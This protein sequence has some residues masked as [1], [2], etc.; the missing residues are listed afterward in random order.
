[1]SAK[2]S[3]FRILLGLLVSALMLASVHTVHA[4]ESTRM[5]DGSGLTAPFADPALTWSTFLGGSGG[6]FA[7][8]MAVDATGNV[9]VI[10]YSDSDWG[11]PIRAFDSANDAF[12]A[13]FDSS[14]NLLWNTF[15]GGGGDDVGLS[16]VTSG[17]SIFVAG[18]SN[19]T[20]DCSPVTCTVN[21]YTLG[22][23][24]FAAKLDSSGNVSWITFLG[25][26]GADF[27]R[28]IA[29]D[30]SGNIYV[31]GASDGT[32]GA[33]IQSHAGGDY[34]GFAAKLNSSGALTWNTFQGSGGHDQTWGIAVDVSG[35]A[36][37]TGYSND[38]WGSPLIAYDADYDGFAA[39]L[40]GS[41]V[42]TWNTFLGGSAEDHSSAIFLDGSGV[43]LT[44]Y[45]TDG[46]GSPV[47]AYTSGNDVFAAKLTSSGALTWN[48]FLGGTGSDAGYAI[49][50]NGSDVYV[51]GYSTDTWGSPDRAFTSGFDGFAAKLNGSGALAW[52][53]FLGGSGSDFGSGVGL[54]GGSL[55][56]GGNS[57][58]TWGTPI[59][60]FD[61]GTDSFIVKFA[62][63]TTP[64]PTPP[65]FADVPFAH[66]ANSW[67]E[68]L[69]NA[70]VT[71]GCATTPHL[72]YCPDAVVTRAQMAIF[73]LRSMHGSAYIPPAATGIVFADVPIDAFAA[74]WIEQLAL[75]GITSGCGDG[76]YCPNATVT[77][78]EMAIFLLRGK[79][80]SAYTPP[81][82]TGIVFGDVPT[83]SFAA[84]WIE[85]LAI[86]GITGGC[87]DGNYCPDMNVTRAEMAVFL[88][89]TF[90]LP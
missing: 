67:I 71:G 60:A 55:Y 37:I 23:D 6:D 45:S 42:L 64:P 11:S 69:Y 48:T 76:N 79:Y 30:G 39:K 75:E 56:V 58:D 24:A 40:D 26:N 50:A 2:S 44:G 33:P 62:G 77:R 46:W 31:A 81:V 1:M 5:E 14:G 21:A 25:S 20:W 63:E 8:N 82:A 51:T 87:G 43:Y 89:R 59:Q 7:Q 90:T 29:V 15:L 12:V 17:S 88:V 86:E 10:G 16:I 73:I 3:V 78:A 61:A 72:L 18:Y 36:Y 4:T 83:G 68:T 66:W 34:D 70:G 49:A 19:D 57:D 85:Q 27:G 54:S 84:D 13:K 53:T 65:I 28:G 32:W 41:G 74:D 80:G 35:N 52:N 38:T 22:Y 9:Y 47:R